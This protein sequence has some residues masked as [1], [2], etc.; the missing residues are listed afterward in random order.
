MVAMF[1]VTIVFGGIAFSTAP[2]PLAIAFVILTIAVCTALARPVVGVHVLLFFSLAGD[3]ATAPWWPFTK[4]LSSRESIMFVSD[5]IPLTPLEILLGAVF[6]SCLAPTVGRNHRP[7]HAG[8]L[9]RPMMWILVFLIVGVGV[10]LGGNR[11]VALVEVRPLL[12]LVLVY[13]LIVNVFTSRSHY[14]QALWVAMGAT[15]LQSLLSLSYYTGLSQRDRA[16]LESLAEHSST[17]QMNAMFLFVLATLLFAGSRAQYRIAGVLAIPVLIAYMLSQR[18]AAMVALFL[19]V[20]VLFVVLFHRR[21]ATFWTVA[22]VVVLLAVGFIG[23]TWN[24][25]GALGLGSGAVKSVF[26]ADQLQESDQSSNLYRELEAINLWSTIRSRPLLGAGFGKPF[27]I[28]VAMPSISFF[29]FWQYIPHNS[30]LWLWIKTGIFG[31]VTFMYTIGRAIFSGTRAVLRERSTGD[32]VILLVGLGYVAMFTVFAYV[33]IAWTTRP[34]VFLAFSLAICTDFHRNAP[35][36]Y[37]IEEFDI[38]R[39]PSFAR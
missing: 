18:R 24:A 29:V 16:G 32:A 4:N 6:L 33:D 22:P 17:V 5:S 20:I 23:A 19:G 14:R 25:T 35:D 37:E 28:V 10:G 38:I 21:R 31:F 11:N 9:R 2:R 8:A 30:L 1:F 39:E 13:V 26:F 7:F 27:D 15:T 12:Y 34:A 3:A 36:P